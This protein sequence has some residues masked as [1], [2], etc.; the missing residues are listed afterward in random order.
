M[1]FL[2]HNWKDKDVVEPIAIRLREIFGQDSVFYD[3]WSIQP[4][5]GIIDKMNEGLAKCKTFLF[6]VSKNSL[7]SK[8]VNLEWQNALY[9][10]T[11]SEVKVVP[12]KLDDCL[13]PPI[14]WQSLYIDLYG[15]G[16]EIAMTQIKDITSGENTFK[17]ESKEFSNLNADVQIFTH[18]NNAQ[19][20]Y[21]ITIN[22]TRFSEP[23]AHFIL[24]SSVPLNN[25]E[26]LVENEPYAVWGKANESFQKAYRIPIEGIY[27]GLQKVITPNH[28]IVIK[29]KSRD[30]TEFK[31]I[32][33]LHEIKKDHYKIIP[34][35]DIHVIIINKQ[36]HL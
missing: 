34:K 19:Y 3:S 10:A 35:N 29:L 2:S 14:L 13:M 20:D 33:I 23:T 30:K 8:M 12:I 24:V 11:K 9:G 1:I 28:P 31:I 36:L 16:L 22:A 32:D 26:Y 7:Q 25:L 27:V 17:G 15:I 6:F 18:Y 4:G 5:E 21:I